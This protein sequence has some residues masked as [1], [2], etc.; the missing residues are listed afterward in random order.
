MVATAHQALA[1]ILEDHPC[2]ELAVADSSLVLNSF[3]IEDNA[4]G[5]AAFAELLRSRHVAELKIMAGVTEDELADLSE[6][7]NVSP[8]DLALRGGMAEELRRRNVVHIR[9]CSGAMP[10]ES[11]EGRE[12]A[13]IYEEA[14]ELIEQAMKAVQ[15]GLQIPV[16][17]I[18]AVVADS[19]QSL[20][21]DGEVLLALA[22]IR[23][24]DRYLSEH[25]VN[26]CILSML[27][28]RDLGID[29]TTTMELG[30][31]AM[32]YDVGKVFVPAEVVKKPTKLAEEEWQMIRMHPAQGARALAGLSDLPVLAATIALEHHAYADGSGYPALPPNHRPHMLSRLVSIVDTYDALTTDRPYRER[33]TGQRAIAWMLYEAPNRY[34]RALLARFASRAGMYPVGAIVRLATGDLAVVVGGTSR[35][36]LRPKVRLMLS[37][38]RLSDETVDLSQR[39]DPSLHIEDIAQPVEAL[40]PYTDRLLAA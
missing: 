7:L 6:A 31:S 40:F 13:D 5:L 35:D 25:S 23:S 16:P 10:A 8:E 24:Y 38:G 4:G 37:D 27:F 26:V 2:L 21:A 30:V 11:R 20:S 28:G 39:A 22:G 33:W 12:P 3:P 32:L 17:E 36:P 14:L 15:S 34:D 9:T 18:R 19:L 29:P 1:G